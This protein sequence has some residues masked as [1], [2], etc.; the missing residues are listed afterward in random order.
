[1]TAPWRVLLCAACALPLPSLADSVLQ[2]KI[3]TGSQYSYT[4]TDQ[5]THAVTGAY[6]LVFVGRDSDGGYLFKRQVDGA[7]DVALKLDPNFNEYRHYV[8]SCCVE[9]RAMKCSRVC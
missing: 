2:P 9:S 8:W 6:T 1:M 3:K 7:A 5:Y 4:V